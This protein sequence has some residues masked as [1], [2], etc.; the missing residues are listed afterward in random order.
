MTYPVV[1]PTTTHACVATLALITEGVYNVNEIMMRSRF[2]YGMLFTEYWIKRQGFII[3][4][5]DVIPWP[6][7]IDELQECPNDWCAFRYPMFDIKKEGL[8]NKG[9]GCTKF[10]RRLTHEPFDT[11]WGETP[12]QELDGWVSTYI[13]K[14]GYEIHI[15]TPPVAHIKALRTTVSAA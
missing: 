1:I 13:E 10:S 7:A 11:I 4:E 6:G 8:C 12:W 3:V 15:H 14:L 9:L 5:H 2:D